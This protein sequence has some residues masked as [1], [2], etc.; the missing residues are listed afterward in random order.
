MILTDFNS[1]LSPSTY[2]STKLRVLSVLLSC[3]YTNI[4]NGYWSHSEFQLNYWWVMID[5][6]WLMYPRVEHLSCLHE[7]ITLKWKKNSHLI[8]EFQPSGNS[9]ALPNLSDGKVL[10][11]TFWAHFK[12]LGSIRPVPHI[13]Q[14]MYD[15]IESIIILSC[16]YIIIIPLLPSTLVRSIELRIVARIVS[17]CCMYV[18]PSCFWNLTWHHTRLV[19]IN[20]YCTIAWLRVTYSW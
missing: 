9:N 13:I 3:M 15:I 8:L 7:D 1:F 16:I 2:P 17:K 18:F 20:C 4:L 14:E 5:P 12:R 11:N 19:M 6:H 10:D